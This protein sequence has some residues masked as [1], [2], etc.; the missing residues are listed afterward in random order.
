MHSS[1][2]ARAPKLQLAVEQPSTGKHWNPPKKDTPH[3]KT[4][5]KPQWDG[6][7]GAITIKSN[8]IPA[9][10]SDPQ[11]WGTIIPKKFSHCCES[12]E[13]DV[14]L[15]TLGIW[16]REINNKNHKIQQQKKV[17]LNETH[18]GYSFAVWELKPEAEHGLV[19]PQL[20][21]IR[22]MTQIFCSS[23]HVCKWP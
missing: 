7:R 22:Q 16:W 20:E 2:P 9:R 4:K 15:P 11:N 18:K 21:H 23:A 5:K 14:R 17:A 13:P 6:R 3:P 1:L 10:L 8:P 19:Q 12:S